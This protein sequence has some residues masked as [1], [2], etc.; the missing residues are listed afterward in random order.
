MSNS[1]YSFIPNLN[2][3]IDNIPPDSILSRTFFDGD[4]QKAIL[5]AFAQGQMLSEHTA[6]KPAVLHF[7]SGEA[8]ITLGEES[9][10]ATSGSWLHMPPNMPHSVHANTPVLMLLYLL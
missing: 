7:L 3:L 4:Q 6:S 5:F 1:T 10:A 2:D 9:M 8:D